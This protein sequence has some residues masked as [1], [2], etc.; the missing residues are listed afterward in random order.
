MIL[1]YFSSIFFTLALIIWAWNDLHSWALLTCLVLIMVDKELAAYS[2][3][4][5]NTRIKILESQAGKLKED[6]NG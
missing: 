6:E 4:D 1:E 2:L 3:R 5:H